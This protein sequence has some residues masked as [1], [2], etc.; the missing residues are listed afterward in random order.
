MKKYKQLGQVWTPR[1]IVDFILDKITL[2]DNMKILEPACGEGIFIS[3]ITEKLKNYEIH[4]VDIDKNALERAKITFKDNPKI[5]FFN[6]DFLK[7][8]HEKG[9]DL[10]ISNPPFIRIQNLE[11]D[12]KE[13]LFNNFS[14]CKGDTDIFYAFLEKSIKILKN[15]G[16]LAFIIPNSWLWSK[17]GENFR[18]F[19]KR[20]EFQVE[21]YDF[22][23]FQIF[24]KI[25]TYI[26]IIILKKS[27]GY[28]HYFRYTGNS[29]YEVSSS[30]K[31]VFE[32]RLSENN[33]FEIVQ[34]H[35]LKIGD[36]RV[37][38]ATLKDKVFIFNPKD[39]DENFYYLDNFKIEK[40]I[41]KEIIKNTKI[42]SKEDI[43]NN[44]LRII[45]PYENGRLI[46]EEKLKEKFPNA[47]EYL[48]A[49]K[50]ILLK[51]DKGKKRYESW[52][53]FGRTQGIKNLFGK[54]ILTPSISKRPIFIYCD[55]EFA[56]FYAGYGI[57]NPPYEFEIMEKIL[58][59]SIIEEYMFIISKPYRDNWRAY[60]KIFLEKI[61]I[62]ILNKDEIE[63][64]RML[65]KKEEIDEFV[66][67]LYKGKR[68]KKVF[69]SKLF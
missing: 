46:D 22:D 10:I 21:V 1:E 28:Y 39:E 54:K 62:P 17:A 25:T 44:K 50:E 9:Y 26:S 41:T 31:N 51:R 45:F 61:K 52:Y 29:F 49:N 19:L 34:N 69:V 12:Y 16:Y 37:G 59:S 32:F 15:N 8:F 35:P 23:H 27:K 40:Q 57:F 18:K 30:W 4:C 6:C 56:L 47:Y 2:F 11:D 67:W 68:T 64:L 55:K 38:I 14:F 13:F 24:P 7:S 53:A 65:S 20:S 3:V 42:K 60:S 33:I 63:K 48:L 36:I 66:L 5:K 58:N 43:K